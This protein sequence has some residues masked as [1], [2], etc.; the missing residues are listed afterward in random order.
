MMKIYIKNCEVLVICYLSF[1]I[2]SP[3]SQTFHGHVGTTHLP[4]LP[5]PATA[6]LLQDGFR[7]NPSFLAIGV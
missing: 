5:S 4:Q 3:I 1:V 7:H 6:S 2:R